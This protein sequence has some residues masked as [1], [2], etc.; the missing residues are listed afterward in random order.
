MNINLLGGIGE[1]FLGHSTS[2]LA[3]NRGWYIA[4]KVSNGQSNAGQP[5]N[6]YGYGLF[7]S[8][9]LIYSTLI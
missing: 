8:V 3:G 4:V 2:T 5:V 6:R 1:T 7:E 9:T